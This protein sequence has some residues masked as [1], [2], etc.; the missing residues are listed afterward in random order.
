MLTS[1]DLISV[2]VSATDPLSAIGVR[3]ELRLHQE[4][5]V[6]ADGSGDD[7]QV[8]VVV[9]DEVDRHAVG[10]IAAF[11]EQGCGRVVVVATRLDDSGVMA[12]VEAGAC[13]V[14]SGPGGG[15]KPGTEPGR[16]GAVAGA[17]RR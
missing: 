4:F 11:H 6:L 15:R 12:A 2:S 14:L 9:A 13:G 16:P 10:V 1:T 8:A 5:R 3:A 17:V 7:A